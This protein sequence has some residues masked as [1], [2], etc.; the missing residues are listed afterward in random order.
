MNKERRAAIAKAISLIEDAEGKIAEAKSM[1]E[2]AR[3]DEQDYYDNMP[4]SFQGGEKGIAAEAAISDIED[5]ITQLEDM[6]TSA[7][8]ARRSA[9]AAVE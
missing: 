6:E 5:A 8:S 4:E 7:E 3:D 2:E 9:E 1:L